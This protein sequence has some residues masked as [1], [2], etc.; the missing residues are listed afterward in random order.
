MCEFILEHASI[1]RQHAFVG[2]DHT[3]QLLITCMGAHGTTI[4]RTTSTAHA[5]PSAT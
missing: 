1:S 5:L 4:N 3:G 2:W